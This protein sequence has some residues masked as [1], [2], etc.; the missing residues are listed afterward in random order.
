MKILK[1]SLVCIISLIL[2][3]SVCSFPVNAVSGSIISFSSN[4]IAVGDS[5]TVTVTI[6][7]GVAMTGV[8]F[9]LSYDANLLSFVSSDYAAGGAG[10]LTFAE[11]PAS[12]TSVSYTAVFS[13][14]A[15]GSSTFK[16]EDCRYAAQ[17]TEG[18]GAQ[19]VGFGGASATLGI[20][21]PALSNNA[22]LKSLKLNVGTLSPSF[23]AKKTSYT[24]NVLY[25]TTKINVTAT[26]A[27]SGAKVVSVTGNDNLKVGKNDVVVT[28][29]AADG[30]QKKYTIVVTRLNEGEALPGADGNDQTE[31]T[32]IDVTQLQ[33]QIADTTYT[34]VTEIP[35][36]N[37]FKGFSVATTKYNEIDVPILVDSAEIYQIYFLKTQDSET[38]TPYI[39][40]QDLKVFEKLKYLLVGDNVYI[41]E[42]IPLKYAIPENLYSS[43]VKISDFSIDCLSS[44]DDNL[45]DMHFVYCYKDGNYSIYRY[46][47][48]ENTLQRYPELELLTIEQANEKDNFFTR[49]SSL[50]TNG[51]VIMI[52]ILLAVLGVFA[53]LVILIIYLIKKASNRGS[54]M[55]YE[56]FED[57]DEEDFE[58]IEEVTETKD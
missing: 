23:S 57:D 17:L 20:K 49:F 27:D 11:S 53:L 55:Y 26:V 32:T 22:N 30:T 16:V 3:I 21:D 40:D 7:P 33:T 34:I 47:S 6:N 45:K 50:S 43:D 25:E 15:T 1:K 58:E 13:A 39:Y 29:Q 14:I 36:Q 37:I 28:V 54:D 44:N 24:T 18:A 52:C 41:F 10:V 56:S 38:I 35:E 31:E 5:V 51:K 2:L 46:D 19:E 9:N 12:K 42:E 8:Q 4:T 48:L